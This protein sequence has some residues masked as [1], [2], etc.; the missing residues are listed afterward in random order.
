MS[1][2]AT[3][4]LT[5]LSQGNEFNSKRWRIPSVAT[6]SLEVASA[7]NESGIVYD[8]TT[9]KLKF[10][11]GTSWANV[12]SGSTSI[13]D[14]GC[15][16]DDGGA[17]SATLTL[18]AQTVAAPT[19]TIPDFASVSD[20]FA[21]VTLAQTLLNKGLTAPTITGGS[22]I[23]L[24]HLSVRDTA[25]AFDLEF[26]S[27][28]TGINADRIITFD[29]RNSARTIDLS[30]NLTLGGNFTTAGAWTH[31]GAHSIGL[32]TTGNTTLV[33]PQGSATTLLVGIDT[34]TAAQGDV[35]FHN[36]TGFTRLAAGAAGQALVTAG[37][38]GNPYWGSV[39]IGT[40]VAISNGC[41]LNDAG[42]NDAV[43]AFT[44]QTVGSPTLTIPDFANVDDTFVF[45]TLAQT[46]ASKTFTAPTING[47]TAIELTGFSLRSTGAAHDLV[48]TT[49]A[50]YTADRT[51]TINIPTTGNASLTLTGNVTW[52]GAFNTEFTV[53]AATTV[54]FPTTGTLA[55]VNGALGT[56]G[57]T[58]GTAVELT[59]LSVR[60]TAAAFD[61]LF[62]STSTGINADRTITFDCR[63]AGRTIDLS[64]NLT[65]GGNF[66]TAGAW[67]HAGAH[68]IGITT[69]NNGTFDFTGAGAYA[70]TFPA[71]TATLVGK[72]TTDVLTN[73]SINCDGA[74]NVITNVNA[75]EL[76]PIT[77]GA[78]ALYA[79]PFVIH[80]QISNPAAAGINIYEDN[81][82][83]KLRI[84]DAWTVCVGGIGT[85]ALTKGKVGALGTVITDTVTVAADKDIDRAGTIDD[86][87]HEIAANGSLAIIGDVG[88][89]LDVELYILAI[90][91]D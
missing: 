44:T 35:Y 41:T 37:A 59:A 72:D 40:A 67:T 10:S 1:T 5:Q 70:L 62:A 52:V 61:L 54:T 16:L 7:S 82:P 84:L 60:D 49:S 39:A 17:N 11:D 57:I 30:G 45:V 23:E 20:T 91:I 13:I 3:R 21:F 42:A 64:G 80:M 68:S 34:A 47:G 6:A 89:A 63:N 65:L 51:L 55:V 27:T 31:T 15:T 90:R 14:D 69:Q 26:K 58:G 75:T 32:T 29:C 86:G 48:V 73:K 88:G 22:A 38:G 87:Q 46:L 18:T 4:F 19:L 8:A 43:L 50:V 56:A 2:W 78:A 74:G 81:C 33:L 66:T 79:V 77:P 9:K 83:Y 24:A 71:A 36:G 76:D 53:T 85:W 12:G 28:S 25:A